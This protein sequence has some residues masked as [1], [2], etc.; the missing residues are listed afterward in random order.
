MNIR[1]LKD[2]E[3]VKLNR[4]AASKGL[5]RE[6]YLRQVIRTHLLQGEIQS[7]ENRYENLVKT[8]LDVIEH[9]T[10]QM[11]ELAE[12]LQERRDYDS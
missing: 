10:E 6:E 9:N 7:I 2:E 5:S 3:I 8:L 11:E 4:L 1:G 12:L